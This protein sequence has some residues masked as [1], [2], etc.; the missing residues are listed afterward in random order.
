MKKGLRETAL[1]LLLALL[2]FGLLEL[3]LSLL[4]VAQPWREGD[5]YGF[6]SE[7]AY[8]VP[9]PDRPGGWVFGREKEGDEE[10]VAPKGARI[11][12]VV[13]GGS[14]A[15]S[16][17]G[18]RLPGALNGMSGEDRFEVVNLGRG[19][20]GSGRVAIVFDQAL[21]RIEPDLALIYTGDN[22][23]VESVFLRMLVDREKE[24]H[25]K[26][27]TRPFLRTRTGTLLARLLRSESDGRPE[28]IQH[29]AL[30]FF[31]N[32]TYAETLAHYDVLRENLRRMLE[33][34]R[35]GGVRVVLM[36]VVYNRFAPPW[37]STIPPD[38]EPD[39]IRAFER[40]RAE[41]LALLPAWFE[42]L[43]LS[44]DTARLQAFDWTSRGEG[45]AE[46]RRPDPD[47]P[48]R[49][50][51]SGPLA[52]ADPLYGD[53]KVWN[54]I[55]YRVFDSLAILHARSPGDADLERAEE[56]LLRCVG[57]LPEHADVHFELALVQ[58]ALGRNV[59][60]VERRFLLAGDL[61]RAPQRANE[62]VNDTIREV[63]AEF[64]EVELFDADAIFAER[65]PGRLVGYEWMLDHCHMTRGGR[66]VMM[67]DLAEAIL[68]RWPD[69]R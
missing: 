18:G 33:R 39:D 27:L 9:D 26:G 5:H 60:E 28:P 40:L 62:V 14:N 20:Y 35:E 50:P 57:L 32:T 29:T 37:L 46:G 66:I 68:A 64:L 12:V 2:A 59:A 4:G 19:A 10:R 25:L 6:D 13:F 17:R 52:N 11:R 7:A 48:G 8:L 24:G 61:D 31:G 55:V 22:E 21:E 49:R 45:S 67:S 58:Y 44:R 36:T 16:F 43:L 1:A 47:L 51:C 56:L 30:R 3:G 41:A 23:F 69:L 38:T 54:E 63:A 42:P 65:M 53:P 34:A 15:Q